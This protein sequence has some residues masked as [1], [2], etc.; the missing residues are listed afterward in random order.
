MPNSPF[1][2]STRIGTSPRHVDAFGTE[3]EVVDQLFHVD[4]ICS[5]DGGATLWL[6]VMTGPGFLRSQSMHC[7]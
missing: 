2:C 5:R 1:G 7:G 6:S 3:L 4:F